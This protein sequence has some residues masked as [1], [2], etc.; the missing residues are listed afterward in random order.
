MMIYVTSDIHGN[1]TRYKKLKEKLISCQDTLY[2]I[3]D[4]LDR[5]KQGFKILDDIM[6]SDNIHL[7]MG[8]HELAHFMIY[9]NYDA[10]C[11]TGNLRFLENQKQWEQYILDPIAGGKQ[12]QEELKRMSRQDITKYM[13][14]LGKLKPTKHIQIKDKHFILSHGTISKDK[15]QGIVDRVNME[16][17]YMVLLN[18]DDDDLIEDVSSLDIANAIT[19]GNDTLLARA[20]IDEY[21]A[22]GY[23]TNATCIVGHTPTCFI[24]SPTQKMSV[25]RAGNNIDIDCGCKGNYPSR[26]NSAGYYG[27]LACLRL[28]DNKIFYFE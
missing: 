23:L 15:V 13:S 27:R 26:K 14:Y 5:G 17:L 16:L 6:E 9:K 20:V 10:F 18:K 12:T 28:D 3:G 21:E 25:L 8:N 1:F 4:V 22:K 19:S 7:L 2:I 11:E 24:Y